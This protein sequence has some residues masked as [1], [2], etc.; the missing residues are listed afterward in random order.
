MK[1]RV[2][3]PT[4]ANQGTRIRGHHT[5][6]LPVGGGCDRVWAWRGWAGSSCIH[7]KP[8]VCACRSR[9]RQLET[10]P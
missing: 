5:Y 2:A 7:E 10:S 8:G 3:H 1:N 9:A 6:L 4:E